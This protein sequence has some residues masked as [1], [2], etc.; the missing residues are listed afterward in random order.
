MLRIW[1]RLG[2]ANSFQFC[3][4]AF[5]EMVPVFT[6]RKYPSSVRRTRGYLGLG[7]CYY[8]W[9]SRQF[10][11]FSTSP[12]NI[13]SGNQNGLESFFDQ[14]NFHTHTRTY[15]GH[16][17]GTTQSSRLNEIQPSLNHCFDNDTKL[18]RHRVD[19]PTIDSTCYK[20]TSPTTSR[21]SA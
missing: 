8:H 5:Q 4:P 19:D 21:R 7:L 15:Y 6:D 12:T 2:S 3:T 20:L 17:R 13:H 11:Q 16:L 1:F 9:R 14:S 18:P 10:S